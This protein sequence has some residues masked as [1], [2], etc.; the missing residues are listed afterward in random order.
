MWRP[1][2]RDGW[3]SC[4]TV[5]GLC[6]A[7]GGLCATDARLPAAGGRPREAV[8]RPRNGGGT[9]CATVATPPGPVAA[10]RA[11]SGLES[12]ATAANRAPS[13]PRVGTENISALPNGLARHP[14]PPTRDDLSVSGPPVQLF[15]PPSG[16][17]SARYSV[18]PADDAR[19]AERNGARN[20]QK[21][22]FQ[23]AGRRVM[24]AMAARRSAEP[25]RRRAI[26][27]RPWVLSVLPNQWPMVQTSTT[28]Q[29]PRE[30]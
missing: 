2:L 16:V 1:P 30:L 9:L 10:S 19:L 6:A 17:F 22:T 13:K 28:L 27:A 7:G 4:V 29:T 12:S 23:V 11:S 18:S 20:E 21:G 8:G 15:S 5:G 25:Q 26:T 14:P 24:R 3:R